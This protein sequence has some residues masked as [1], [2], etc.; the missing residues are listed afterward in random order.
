MVIEENTVADRLIHSEN[1]TEGIVDPSLFTYK[2]FANLTDLNVFCDQHSKMLEGTFLCLDLSYAK[3]DKIHVQ[4]GL[5]SDIYAF[6]Y[7]EEK[8]NK[9]YDSKL[10]THYSFYSEELGTDTDI[11]MDVPYHSMTLDFISL[12]QN[13]IEE[14]LQYEFYR[15]S[16][17]KVIW[18]HLIKIYS[19]ENCIAY[20]Y[21][22]TGLDISREWVVS[23]LNE[24]ITL[25]NN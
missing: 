11:Y 5:S 25:V 13:S 24:Y 6:D 22:Y 3:E 18:N 1:I 16:D 19:G 9:Y 20:V 21:Y 14:D 8:N 2:S 4:T 10:T 12:P 17:E 23:F 7:K 15:Y